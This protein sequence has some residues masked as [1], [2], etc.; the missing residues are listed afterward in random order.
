MTKLVEIRKFQV[1]TYNK[2][3]INDSSMTYLDKNTFDELER[4]LLEF[5]DTNDAD[6]MDFFRLV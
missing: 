1:I 2:D 4:F 6:A 3:Y 5:T